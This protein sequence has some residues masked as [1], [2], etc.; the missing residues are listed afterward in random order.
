MQK[1]YGYNAETSRSSQDGSLELDNG[2]TQ[3]NLSWMVY[4]NGPECFI[5]GETSRQ[6]RKAPNVAHKG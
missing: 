4:A 1:R 6:V 2:N 5:A 3:R